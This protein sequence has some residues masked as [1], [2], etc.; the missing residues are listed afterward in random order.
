[1]IAIK[2]DDATVG[3]SENHK[4]PYLSRAI[5]F[6][7]PSVTPLVPEKRSNLTFWVCALSSFDKTKRK[8][9]MHCLRNNF[10]LFIVGS[11]LKKHCGLNPACPAGRQDL[12]DL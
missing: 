7:F 12:C 4:K 3:W 1:M 5:P 9:N 11:Y 2:T 8:I 6:I 10:M